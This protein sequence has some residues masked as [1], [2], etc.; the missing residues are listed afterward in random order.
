MKMSKIVGLLPFMED[1]EIKELA[2]KILNDEVQGMKIVVLYPFLDKEDLEDIVKVCIEKQ[3]KTEI[4]SA[5]PFLSK[6]ALHE[7]YQSVREG[8]LE[9]FK[10]QVFYP[11]LGKD[12]VKKVYK[13]LIKEAMEKGVEQDEEVYVYE[14]DEE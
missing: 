13:D 2:Y 3:K 1:E 4:Y 14:D 12:E 6:K 9:G 8:K 10:E 11:F 5:L 7:I